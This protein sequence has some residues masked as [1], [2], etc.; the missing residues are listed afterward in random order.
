MGSFQWDHRLQQKMIIINGTIG[1]KKNSIVLGEI[2]YS[3]KYLLFFI[4]ITSFKKN[5]R[6]L[7]KIISVKCKVCTFPIYFWNR[8]FLEASIENYQAFAEICQLI[9]KY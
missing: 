6:T 8:V 2:K 7:D 1:F 9:E 3:S 4:K 5:L